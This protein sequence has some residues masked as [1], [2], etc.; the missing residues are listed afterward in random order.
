MGGSV[1][2]GEAHDGTDQP[3]AIVIE[4]H[5]RGTRY[6][7]WTSEPEV[8]GGSGSRLVNMPAPDLHNTWVATFRDR[9]RALDYRD[10]INRREAPRD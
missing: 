3:Y 6:S 8:G 10:W 5:N 2:P 9:R 1:S 7:V 4:L